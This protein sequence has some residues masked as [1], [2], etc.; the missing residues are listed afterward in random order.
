MVDQTKQQD[1]GPQHQSILK[2]TVDHTRQQDGGPQCQSILNEQR[3]KSGSKMTDL[4]TTAYWL[5]SGPDQAA[6][7]ST[8]EPLLESTE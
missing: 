7:W 6:K 5:N 3:T 4:C 1:G 2:G 8:P